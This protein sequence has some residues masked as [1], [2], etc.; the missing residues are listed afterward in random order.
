M[1]TTSANLGVALALLSGAASLIGAAA[2]PVTAQEGER[3]VVLVNVLDRDGN[4]VPGLS[5]ANFRGKMR[6]TPVT[7]LSA[8]LDAEPRRIALVMDT[9]GSLTGQSGGEAAFAAARDLVSS[10]TPQHRV[11][12]FSVAA[13]VKMHSN[14]TNDRA[15]LR[16]A[17]GEAHDRPGGPSALLDGLSRLSG[18]LADS[19][20]GDAICLFTDGEDTASRSDEAEVIA[21]VAGRGVRVFVVRTNK[22]RPQDTAYLIASSWISDV[23]KATGGSH[24]ALEEL[25]KDGSARS[26]ASMMTA[27]YRLEVQLP[28][29]ANKPGKWKLEV[30]GADGKELRDAR[31]VYPE[32]MPSP[33]RGAN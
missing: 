15:T 26:F 21:T 16:S 6:G 14:L 11:A 3:R 2:L 24:Y 10:L 4:Q 23:T 18:V 31:L 17:L 20:L 27:G 13:G 1:T 7:I 28:G 22:A 8:A 25:Q 30:V 9:S 5:A 29:K 33:V 32:V 19:A 12:V